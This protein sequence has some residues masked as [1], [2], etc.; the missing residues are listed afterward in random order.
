MQMTMKHCS[1]AANKSLWR[2]CRK[3]TPARWFNIQIWFLRRAFNNFSKCVISLWVSWHVTALEAHLHSD[4]DFLFLC[5]S[6]SLFKVAPKSL[7]KWISSLWNNDS[8]TTVAPESARI[9]RKWSHCFACSTRALEFMFN[10]SS[11]FSFTPRSV[12]APATDAPLDT[13]EVY[14]FLKFPPWSLRPGRQPWGTLLHQLVAPF[15]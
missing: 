9:P 8:R 7:L 10:E 6:A 12:M 1:F 14:N 11:L 5:C 2:T 4:R 15:T 3:C 13:L